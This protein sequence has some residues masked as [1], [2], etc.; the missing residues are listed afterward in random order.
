MKLLGKLPEKVTIAFSGGVDSVAVTHFLMQG[1]RDITL[2]YFNHLTNF[3][4]ASKHFVREFAKRNNLPLEIG[5]L[6]DFRA[7]K[8]EESEEEYWR[9][10]RYN[11]FSKYSDSPM[12]TC[13]HLDDQVETWFFTAMHNYPKLIPYRRNNIIRPF[14]LVK[15][16]EIT[17]YANKHDLLWMDDP[18]NSDT[19]YPRNRIRWNVIPEI[20]AINPGI[21]K[22]IARKVQEEYNVKEKQ[23]S[24]E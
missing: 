22:V 10:A 3:G 6:R 20:L 21:Y 4:A 5:S 7:R 19:K 1:R 15:K 8:E 16:S 18:S 11:F 12:I 23:E 17:A 24:G 14:L 13:H 2:L 9:E